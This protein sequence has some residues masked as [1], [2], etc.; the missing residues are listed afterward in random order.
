M[1]I[2]TLWEPYATLMALGEKRVETR[3]WYTSYRGPT[4][5]HAAKL[6]Q[7]NYR[8]PAK[9]ADTLHYFEKA[10][11][12]V[13]IAPGHVVAVVNVAECL[14][15]G[16]SNHDLKLWV[17]DIL[18]DKEKAFGDY[19]AHRY[20]W[21]TDDVFRLPV[22]I[23]YKGGQGL[24]NLDQKIVEQIKAQGWMGRV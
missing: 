18:S 4:A 2:L 7:N 8:Y 10:L 16:T 9:M 17:M 12:G 13:S 6:G 24:R 20:G 1:K 23:P 21:L 15:T 22:P 3:S 19:S 14:F 5:I 11:E